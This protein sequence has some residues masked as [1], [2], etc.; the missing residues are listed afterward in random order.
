[1]MADTPKETC[2]FVHL[3][4]HTEYSLLDGAARIK[5]LVQRAADLN[6]PA[7]AITDHGVMY[8]VI[9]FYK[10]C[11]QAGIKPIIGCEV[12]VAPHKRT[13]KA[14]GKDDANFHLVLLAENEQGYRNLIRLVSMAHIEGF[15]YKPRVDKEILR[16]HSQGLIALSA[17]LAGEVSDHLVHDQLDM[18][19]EK[20]REYEDIFG[21]GNFFLEVQDH[22]L[23]EQREVNAGMWKVHERTG[24]PMVATNDVHYVQ[25]E[26]AFVQDALLCIQTG[27]TLEDASRMRFS[28]QEFFLKSEQEMA[29][30]FGEH[31]ELLTNTQQIAQRCQLDFQF[32]ENYLPVFDVPA[33]YTLDSFLEAECRKAFP[34]FYPQMTAKEQERL[35]YELRVIFQ[36]GFSGYFLIVADFCRYARANGVAVGPG[37]GSA[38]ASM[39]AYLLGITSVEPM[40]F[41][42]LFERFLNPERVSMP[43]I[44]IDFDPEGR[45]RVI[46]YV[47]DKY[48]ADKV[49][50]IITFGTMGAKA[51]IR[52]VGRVMAIPL[53]RVDKVAKAIPSDPGMTLEKAL[54]VSPD[55]ARL[56]DEDEE[57]KR[58]YTLAKSLEG[59]PRHASTHAAGIVISKDSLVNYL[60][61]QR[62]S[63][64][65]VMTQFPMKTVEEIGLLKMDFLGL[66]NLTILQE[67]VQRIEETQGFK[68]D[69]HTLALDD[70][71]TYE[72]LS[73]GNSTGIF[74]LE[75]G[76]MRGILKDLKP[77]C[78]E[79]IIAV[80]AL[81]RPGP[82]EQI[83]EFLRRKHGGN[84][85]YLHPKLEPILKSTYGV[86]V[87]QEQVMQIARDLA[88]YSLGRA[89]LLRRAMGKKKKEIMAEERQNF[90]HGLQDSNGEWIIPGA[91]RL[92]LTLKEAEE[93]FDLM[94]KF[95]EYGFNKGHATAYAVISYQT[96][97]LKANYPL[98]F[99][100]ALLST[101]MGSSDKIS[102]YIQDARLSGIEVLP[103][104]VQYS[105][106]GFSIEK[107]AIRF[108]LGAIRN[109]G[110]NVVEKILEARKEG[111]FKS[112]DD[113]CLR[114]DQ[115][116][117]NKRVMESLIRA[118]AFSSLCSRNQALKVMDQVLE[119]TG[120]RQKD[121]LSGQ[122][123]LF[124]F[125]EGMD[126]VTVLPQVPDLSER[127]ILDME[128]E[129]LGLYLSGHPLSSVLPILKN[130]ISSDI[131]TC[132][133]G[134]EEKKVILGG[135]VTGFRQNV[136]KKGEMM[137]SFVLEDL[138]AGIEVLVFPRVYAQ[139]ASLTND[140]VIV[141]TGRYNIRDDEK[142]IFAEKITKLEDLKPG[143]ENSGGENS[144]A[145]SGSL[146]DEKI[147][148]YHAPQAV[149]PKRLFLR[150]SHE[151]TDIMENVLKILQRYPG[152]QPVYFYFEDT[153]KVLEGNRSYW[154]SDQDELTSALQKVLNQQ[155]VVWQSVKN[156]A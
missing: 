151:S 68:L 146:P 153:R 20:A 148:A 47:T 33:G 21:K 32:G 117:L 38:A 11:R 30:L 120:R 109:V 71:K 122:F 100:A 45:E 39:V 23:E 142:K 114:V 125:D 101:V 15:Y 107:Q 63:E 97:Y 73:S 27:K 124:D 134:D 12:Y 154:V 4:N 85:T 72:L 10:A 56:I 115:K 54:E 135:L 91:L 70:A 83:P 55:L 82:M 80:I 76:G 79:D 129:Y 95:A 121:R 3:H 88:G 29:L 139:T 60:P 46:H 137:A 1:M 31:P 131:L 141:V 24:I 6:M 57:T 64:D 19:V 62:T 150:F 143:G 112:L 78:F 116:V 48:G 8:G 104:D 34:H 7:L 86:I 81:Y 58:L 102:F 75:S 44:D 98:E 99:M 145:A 119:S 90:V 155:N 140:D 17:C 66:R 40:R 9:D 42:L 156:F 123:S 106:V 37:R 67:A 36:T 108:G 52:D 105:Q 28:S 92:G 113:F 41:D 18:A 43:D 35:E 74:Q 69:L 77:S 50:Q 126:E 25:R 133:E 65:F 132:L 94:A 136:T 138:T 128:K 53:Y 22:G 93:I 59:M 61:L 130:F 144:V 96:A 13:D 51:A 84:I 110:V 49:C 87:Y 5:S 14:A 111:I 103:P 127:E 16:K 118:G 152:S 2:G 147:A 89:D 149:L 26:D